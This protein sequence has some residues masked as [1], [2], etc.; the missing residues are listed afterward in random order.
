MPRDPRKFLADV[1]EACARIQ[2]FV[3]GRSY[4]DYLRDELLR[5]GVERQFA[6][7]GEAVN[8]LARVAPHVAERIT[9]HHRVIAFRNTLIHDYDAVQHAIVWG[10]IE[11]RI[12][13]LNQEA[14]ALLDELTRAD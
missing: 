5:S 1:A 2:R 3:E 10:V 8:R 12:S 13:L 11:T 6:I 9:D 7:I 14:T 4:E